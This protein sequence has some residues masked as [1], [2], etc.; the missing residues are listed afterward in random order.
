MLWDVSRIERVRK[1]GRVPGAGGDVWIRNN[2]GVAHYAGLTTCGSIW[3]CPVCSA[4][5]RNHRAEEIST[6]TA[7]WDRQ[8]N[9]VYMATFTA[10]H[11]LGMKLKPLLSTI[12]DGF[13]HVVAGRAWVKLKKQL[14]IVG[15]IRS[16]EI[17]HGEHGWH[18][19][20]HVLIYIDGQLGALGLAQLVMH[21]RD[22]WADFITRAGYRP[23]HEDHGV[24]VDR[25]TSATEAGLYIA[26]TQDGR[27]VGNE[28]AR[29]DLKQGRRGGRVP[30]E[31]L[32]DFR[33]TGDAGDLQLW[34]EYEQATKGR[35]CIT[36]S[37]G[38]RALL[39]GGHEEKT[40]E[41]VAAEEIGGEDVAVIPGDTWRA[42]TRVPGLPAAL[43]DACERAGLDGINELLGRF[44]LGAVA[45][46]PPLIR[47]GEALS[48][49][50]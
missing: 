27:S 39:L 38:L 32:D 50:V 1:C 16:M 28:I 31:V 17:T 33:W 11:D 37:K 40:D 34:H 18:P 4:K 45:P 2:E 22:R 5:I 13:R 44:G 19:H 6:A 36:W 35:Q 43:L 29:G 14:R 23:P 46:P 9:E 10:P 30:F 8:G 48:F 26:K 41:E 20:L 24:K 12:A 42:V 21:L 47:H 25:C 15:Q 49:T 7:A 3:A